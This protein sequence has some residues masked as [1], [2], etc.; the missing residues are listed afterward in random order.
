MRKKIVS[1][2]RM[3]VCSGMQLL[4]QLRALCYR[5]PFILITAFGDSE[6]REHAR[7][8][9]A[10][11]FDKPFDIDDLGRAVERLLRPAV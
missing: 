10:L 5:I 2:I 11:L 4:E 7:Q 6:S 1:D 9:G 8:L 3:P